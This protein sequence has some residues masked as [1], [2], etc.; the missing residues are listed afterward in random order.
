[1]YIIYKNKLTTELVVRLALEPDEQP[2][3]QQQMEHDIL[4]VVT[5]HVHD[6]CPGSPLEH[7]DAPVRQLGDN[8]RYARPNAALLV[9]SHGLCST[10]IS[11][12]EDVLG[13]H[14]RSSRVEQAV[15]REVDQLFPLAKIYM[16]YMVYI[17]GIGGIG[18]G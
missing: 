13:R 18:Y 14:L 1:M 4:A 7:G 15:Y 8:A 5:Q 9:G 17:G 12:A 10:L 11:I 3:V 16:V 2:A 6:V